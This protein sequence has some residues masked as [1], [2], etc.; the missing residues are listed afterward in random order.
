MHGDD[1]AQILAVTFTNKA[2]LEILSA[3]ISTGLN[4]IKDFFI[5]NG[6][7]PHITLRRINKNQAYVLF[8]FV[9]FNL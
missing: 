2:A 4:V 6:E 8:D 1:P 3:P 7:L 9:I 5:K